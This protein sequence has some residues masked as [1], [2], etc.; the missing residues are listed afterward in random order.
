MLRQEP[1]TTMAIQLQSGR[2]DCPDRLFFD[3]AGCWASCMKST[4]DVKELI[5]EFFTC[6]EM[7]LNTNKY[8]LGKTQTKIVVDDVILPQWAN[9]SPYECVRLHMLALE[10]EHV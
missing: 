5:P 9:G 8:D 2:F 10:S 1:F 6:P 4:S 3:I 7:F